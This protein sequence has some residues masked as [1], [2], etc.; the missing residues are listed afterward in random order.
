MRD[1][2]SSDFAKTWKPDKVKA[3]KGVSL[4]GKT[5]AIAEHR[6]ED[7]NEDEVDSIDLSDESEENADAVQNPMHATGAQPNAAEGQNQAGGN[8]VF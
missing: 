2:K 1:T 5:P 8:N 7:S 6:E 4:D 3:L